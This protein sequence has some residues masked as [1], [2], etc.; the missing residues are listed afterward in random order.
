MR[1]L[2]QLMVLNISFQWYNISNTGV[3]FLKFASKVALELNTLKSNN[4]KQYYFNYTMLGDLIS[5]EEITTEEEE[6][7]EDSLTFTACYALP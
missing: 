5:C 7:V 4:T 3:N 6:E 2:N 1:T